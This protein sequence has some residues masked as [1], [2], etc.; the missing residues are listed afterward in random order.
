M[1]YD[2]KNIKEDSSK[3]LIT[4]TFDRNGP[5][6]IDIPVKENMDTPRT[7]GSEFTDVA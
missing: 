5:K 7:Q 3:Q 1:L 6:V 2:E 4:Q